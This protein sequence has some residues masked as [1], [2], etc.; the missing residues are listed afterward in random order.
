MRLAGRIV[1]RAA[2]E[3]R[4]GGGS[5]YPGGAGAIA[6]PNLRLTPALQRVARRIDRVEESLF[7]VEI[8]AVDGIVE[9]DDPPGI[10]PPPANLE[11]H[12]PHPIPPRAALPPGQ[13]A[14]RSLGG[15][16]GGLRRHLARRLL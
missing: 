4:S 16:P 3:A 9:A 8:G 7:L 10:P 1:G 6:Q 12:D 5:E 11:R 14:S 15:D 13:D 2:A